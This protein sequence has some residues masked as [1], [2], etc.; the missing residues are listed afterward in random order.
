M[1]RQVREFDLSSEIRRVATDFESVAGPLRQGGARRS[2][3]AGISRDNLS[4]LLPYHLMQGFPFRGDLDAARAMSR[5]N[6]FGA[7]HF[8]AQ[9]RVLDGVEDPTPALCELCDVCMVRFVRGYA[10]LFPKDSP[11]WNMFDRYIGEYFRSL[12]WEREVLWGG[13]GSDAVRSEEL[14]GT[15]VLL[16]RKMS[17]LK[18]TVAAVAVLSGSPQLVET[19]ERIVEAFHAAYQLADDLS[20]LADDAASGRWSTA[21]RLVALAAGVQEVPAVLGADGILQLA[22][23]CGAYGTI[24]EL[25]SAQYSV[26]LALARELDLESL[27]SHLIRLRDASSVFHAWAGRRATI[28]LAAGDAGETGGALDFR[29]LVQPEAEDHMGAFSESSP[30]PVALP[31]NLHAFSVA[32]R[33]FVVDGSSGLFFESDAVASD[34]FACFRAASPEA[35]L[36]VA[37]MDHGSEAVE[38]ALGEIALL[39]SPLPPWPR[40]PLGAGGACRPP[41][42]SLALNV[43]SGCNLS[44][45]Y[46]Y[47]SS[48]E[49]RPVE[50]MGRETALR[51]IDLLI[52]ESSG[53]EGISLVFFGGE[54]LLQSELVLATSSMA[55]ERAREC[56]RRLALHLTTNGTLLTRGVA[57]S[58]R[59]LGVSILVSIDGA[60][61]QHDRHRKFRD[62]SGSYE[63]VASNLSRLPGEMNASARVTVTPGSE[64]LVDTVSHLK[65]LGFRTV[66]LA[67][68][69]GEALSGEFERWLL[70]EMEELAA[71]E[72][73]AARSGAHL[74]VG[75]FTRVLPAI[76]TG[77][78]RSLACGAGVRYLCVAPDGALY[79]CHRFTGR[80]A[81]AVGDVRSGVDGAAIVRRLSGLRA[82]ARACERC[83]ARSLCGGPCLYDMDVAGPFPEASRCA[84]TRRTLELSMWLYSSLPDA[85]RRSIGRG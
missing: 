26:A 53:E 1:F 65:T 49:P 68:V 33:N 70:A 64:R 41:V 10:E 83:W 45:D 39:A 19:G 15:L 61:G 8:I 67:A 18:A 22:V 82:G 4:L 55:R 40:H 56:G 54:P 81:F 43:T 28:L 2:G 66:H 57:T 38:E 46:C 77:R 79:V 52:E 63:K 3:D 69:S 72:L 6:A 14:P 35:A 25:T 50:F 23:A 29:R 7:A 37:R 11:F 21:L 32:E 58:L 30:S 73:D 74:S 9:D 76:G 12:R 84:V 71:W 78:L 51:A 42:V 13:A 75:N 36:D 80:D 48:D 16:G 34:I 44:C 59:D 47:L 85:A 27:A 60:P 17:P 5:A 62:G 24:A 20:D 31:E